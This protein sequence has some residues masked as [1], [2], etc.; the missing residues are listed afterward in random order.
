MRDLAAPRRRNRLKPFLATFVFVVVVG[1]LV[2]R[3]FESLPPPL[4][5]F[6]SFLQ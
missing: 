5:R 1:L 4:Q 2:N 6:L 3:F